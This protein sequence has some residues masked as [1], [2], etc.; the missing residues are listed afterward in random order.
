MLLDCVDLENATQRS[1]LA[2]LDILTHGARTSEPAEL[3]ES[4][5]FARLLT[6]CRQQ[7]DYVLIDAPPLLAVADPSIIAPHVDSVVLTIRVLSNCR[8]PIERCAQLLRELDVTPAALVVNSMEQNDGKSF[9]YSN[10]QSYEAYG[11]VGYYDEYLVSDD[12]ESP[13]PK[14]RS[15]RT[16]KPSISHPMK[17]A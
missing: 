17:S 10:T 6:K 14:Q 15:R 12:A 7:Y 16:I 2:N 3:L 9:G 4:A 11:Y 13:R 8:R 5:D 1:E